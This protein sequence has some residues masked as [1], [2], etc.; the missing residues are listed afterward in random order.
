MKSTDKTDWMFHGSLFLRYT[1]QDIFSIGSRG[2]DAFSAPNRF[3]T[4][5]NKKIGE[6]GLLNATAMINLDRLTEGGNGYPLLFQSGETFEGKRL[7]DR[8]HP[9]DL[10]SAL[11]IGYTQ[12]LNKDIDLTVYCE[13]GKK[14]VMIAMG[15]QCVM[16]GNRGNRFIAFINEGKVYCIMPDGTRV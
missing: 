10:F 8:Q 9:H 1:N 13:A 16:T 3:M 15:K 2:A 5:M 11:S 14:E 4:M 12:M 7:V 6:K